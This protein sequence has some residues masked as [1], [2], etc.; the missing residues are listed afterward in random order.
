MNSTLK[1]L[2]WDCIGEAT[3]DMNFVAPV[4]RVLPPAVVERLRKSRNTL[5]FYLEGLFSVEKPALRWTLHDLGIRPGDIVFVQSSYDQMRSI[6]ATPSEII[7]ILCEAVG[8]SGTIVMPTFP[9][10]GLS[11]H[12][13]EQHPF[14]DW[15][16]TPS[17]S[18][19][20]SEIFRRMPGTERSVHPSHPVAARGAAA[21]W[22]TKDHDRSETPFDEHSPFQKLLQCNALILTIGRFKAM[23]FRHLADHLLQD[24]IPYPIY[25]DRPTS[26]RV[27]DK[28][29]NEHQL[30]VKGHNPDIACNHQ[31][32]LD[33]MARE[34]LLRRAKV[35]RVRLSLMDTQQYIDAYDRY[36][37]GE[38][39]CHYLKSRH[40][41][42]ASS[43]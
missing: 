28:E 42:P 3:I 11:Q 18:G 36:Y 16:R 12:H 2:L 14:F 33:R 37:T 15:R 34:G 26:V 41:D 21:A 6:R 7:E 40:A 43:G 20:L 23:T 13:L 8:N 31:L 38:A 39:F 17:Q 35:G 22:L 24:K 19:I 30:L 5:L 1:Y 10:S 27:I 9:M 25:S 29:G 32:V 4:K